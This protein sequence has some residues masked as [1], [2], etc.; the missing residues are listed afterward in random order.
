MRVVLDT[1]L[2]VSRFLSDRGA[3]ARIFELW[4]RTAFELLASEPILAEYRRLLAYPKVQT[5]HRHSDEKLDKLI[6]EWRQFVVLVEPAET[7]DVIPDDPADNRILECA[8]AGDADFV[9]SGDR[10]LLTL[11]QFRGIVILSPAAFLVLVT[12]ASG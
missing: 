3:P 5:H 12:P 1:N 4:R 9:V 6:A 7:L 8:V 2:V 10:H 11:R